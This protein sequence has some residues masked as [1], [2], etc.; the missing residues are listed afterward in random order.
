MER[1]DV[2][3]TNKP[4]IWLS[5]LIAALALGAAGTGLFWQDRGSS[6][7]FT[8]LH[9]QVVQISGRG[10]YHYDTI[11]TASQEQSQ[12]VVTVFLGVPLLVVS[13]LLSRRGSLRGHLLLAGTLGY[14]LYTYG[15]MAFLTAYNALFLVYVAL[16]SASLFAFVLAFTSIDRQDLPSHFSSHLPRCSIAGFLFAVGLFLLLLWLGLLVPPLWQGHTP[17][18]LESATTL[19]IQVLDLGIIV[20][21]AVLSGLL[22]LRRAPLGYL[23]TSVVLIKSV[24]LGT[25]V[26]AMV[27]G[28]LLA[29]VQLPLIQIVGFPLLALTGTVLTVVLL[30]H[31]S[32]GPRNRLLTPEE[33]RSRKPGPPDTPKGKAYGKDQQGNRPLEESRA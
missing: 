18:G 27:V 15:S 13:L 31:V 3:K 20:P 17:Q 2:M 32:R 9:D 10:L 26:S 4:L 22:L 12:D 28:Q 19:V 7:A 30:H 29:G 25:A 11:A 14:F 1:S 33:E 24:T 16:F 21:V 23:L 6:Y 8:T 5:W